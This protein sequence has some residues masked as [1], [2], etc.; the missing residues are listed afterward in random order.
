L[1]FKDPTG[2]DFL[3]TSGKPVPPLID[4]PVLMGAADKV[5]RGKG[6]KGD[7]DL[8]LD[9]GASLGGARPKAS[10]RGSNGE[11]LI[12]KFP[13]TDDEWPVISWEAVTLELAKAAGVDVPEWTLQIVERKAVLLLQRFDRKGGGLRIPFMSAMTALD[14]KDHAGGHSYL[15]IVA[16]IRR[17]GSQPNEALRQLWRRMVFNILVSNIDDHLRNHAFLRDTRGWQLTPAF[18]MNPSP[19]GRRT[20]AIAF[21]DR[22]SSGSFNL[23]LSVAPQ[24]GISRAD[25]ANIG[26]EVGASVAKW[27]EV[28][29]RYKLSSSHISFMATAFEHGDIVLAQKNIVIAKH[30]KATA[31]IKRA[32]K[33]K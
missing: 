31:R 11:L 22:D 27:R 5:D 33:P 23:A 1:R 30:P 7:V 15:E 6:T 25:A 19:L 18:D 32:I 10:V 12:A 21:D 26:A 17:Y 2:G 8:V 24:F 20:H 29:K 16:F 28:A 13:K 9:P 14:A 4:L 3:M